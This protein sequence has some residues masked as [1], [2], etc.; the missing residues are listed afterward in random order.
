MMRRN[1]ARRRTDSG[2]EDLQYSSV[3]HVDED[4]VMDM[5]ADDTRRSTIP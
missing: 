1:K 5:T 2:T 3:Q 4:W